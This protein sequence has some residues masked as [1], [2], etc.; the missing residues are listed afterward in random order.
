MASAKVATV[1]FEFIR[2]ESPVTSGKVG[3]QSFPVCSAIRTKEA[4]MSSSREGFIT[5]RS[6]CAAR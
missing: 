4:R 2:R 6:G 1:W 5:T 3:A